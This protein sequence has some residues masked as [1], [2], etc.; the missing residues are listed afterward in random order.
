MVRNT[1]PNCCSAVSGDAGTQL[2]CLRNRCHHPP[3]RAGCV[4]RVSVACQ[5]WAGISS[6]VALKP[7]VTRNLPD[8]VS[9]Q[10]VV[11]LGLA[12]TPNTDRQWGHKEDGTGKPPA[13]AARCALTP[14][15]LLSPRESVVEAG[16]VSHDGFLIWPQS[17]Y[18]ICTER[19]RE[20]ERQE[21]VKDA[22]RAAGAGP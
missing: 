7:T 4:Q 20:R 12:R 19:E 17:A 22:G 11:A 5:H 8:Q 2:S 21:R 13:T 16:H 15:H 3:H 10:A 1:G 14:A 6:V 18:N 9:P